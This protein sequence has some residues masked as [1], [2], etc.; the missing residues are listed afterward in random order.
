MWKGEGD[1]WKG[2][3]DVFNSIP[4]HSPVPRRRKRKAAAGK[5]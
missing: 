1:V 4:S 3:D 2:E 5:G